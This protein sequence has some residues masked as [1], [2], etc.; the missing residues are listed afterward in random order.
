MV[1]SLSKLWEIVDDRAFCH[2]VVHGIANSGT[3][4]S[5]WTTTLV[6]TLKEGMSY[7]HWGFLG[8]EEK[9]ESS[10]RGKTKSSQIP[11]SFSSW[12]CGKA[13]Y[14]LYPLPTEFWLENVDWKWHI[15]LADLAQKTTCQNL[16]VLSLWASQV[17]DIPWGLRGPQRWWSHSAGVWVSAWTSPIPPILQPQF[18]VRWAKNKTLWES[19]SFW[20]CL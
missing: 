15:P 4:L 9:Q 19:L 18:T 6:S 7:G 11:I 10:G 14:P 12:A 8:K 13:S 5:D 20:S 1:M 2:A 3:Q 16:P 17:Q